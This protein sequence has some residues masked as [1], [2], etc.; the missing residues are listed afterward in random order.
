MSPFA[1]PPSY[2]PIHG[3]HKVLL[4]IG[5]TQIESTATNTGVYDLNSKAAVE[6][7]LQYIM[8]G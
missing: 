4:F 7:G 6:S 5:T 8:A 1:S 2:V 3:H